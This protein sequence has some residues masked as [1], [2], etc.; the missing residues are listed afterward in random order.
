MLP[1]QKESKMI[2]EQL[3]TTE[4][5]AKRMR[6][7]PSTGAAWPGNPSGDR[8]IAMGFRNPFRWTFRPGMGEVWIGDVGWD[9]WEEID[10]IVDPAAALTGNFGWPC[11][12][13]APRQAGFDNADLT[14]CETLYSQGPSAVA[15]PYFAY[16]HYQKLDPNETCS[17]ANS[18]ITGI[19]FYP[20]GSYPASYAD[21]LFFV[22][23]SRNCMWVM[24]KGAN[25]L[26]DPATVHVFEN[27]AAEPVDLQRGPAGDIFYVDHE[28]GTIHRITYTSGNTPPT[29][30]AS[31]TPRSGGVP[32]T[33]QFDGSLSSDPDLGAT[34]SFA[35]DLDGGGQFDDAFVANPQHIY[36][37]AGQ[38]T[39]RLR[40][41]DEHSASSIASVVVS[42]GN[43]AP[44]ATVTAP[45]PALTWAVV[46]R[47]APNRPLTSPRSRREP[48]ISAS[49]AASVARD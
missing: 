14:L 34:L 38:I 27:G 25:G 30:I 47:H 39:V 21:A 49:S 2:M 18:S 35:W 40:V 4:E 17:T 33:V 46:S 28:G 48:A 9:T 11:Y 26:P 19:A 41:T 43:H 15:A 8:T 24:N 22:D 23:H 5:L 42:P 45:L 31:A 6:V 7:N 10:R 37:S 1:A 12:E 3:L 13:G 16:Q 36:T 20:S 29:S 44:V 32:L